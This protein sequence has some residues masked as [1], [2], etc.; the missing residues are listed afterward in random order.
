MTPQARLRVGTRTILALGF[1]AAIVI[2]LIA[3]PPPENPLGYDPMD[4][5]KYLHDL[6]VYGGRANVVA[7]EF[8]DWFS[9]LWHGQRLAFTVAAITLMTTWVFRF[10][11]APMPEDAE[12]PP[13]QAK[14]PM[15][16]VRGEKKNDDLPGADRRA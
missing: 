2:Y 7:A 6:E 10:F 1:A 8:M 12:A 9:S 4:T 3:Q 16:L 14:P 15:R 13:A 5:K 11:A